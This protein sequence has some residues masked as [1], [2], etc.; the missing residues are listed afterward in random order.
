M[1]HGTILQW[2]R[3]I[4]DSIAKDEMLLELET[5]KAIVELPSPTDG[6]LLSILHESGEVNVDQVIGWIGQRGEAVPETGPLHTP[7]QTS[8]PEA[9]VSVSSQNA[10]RGPSAPLLAATPAARRRAKELGIDLSSVKGTGPGGRITEENVEGHAQAKSDL[11]SSR[12]RVLAEHVTEAWRNVP[13]IHIVRSMGMDSL[14]RAKDVLSG[15]DQPISYTDLVLFTLAKTLTRF[16][17]VLFSPPPG[18]TNLS[19]AFAVDTEHGVV[20]PAIPGVDKLTL[21]QLAEARRKLTSLAQARKLQPEHLQTANFT[22]TNLGMFG[23]DLFAPIINTP[24]I[25]ILAVGQIA[26]Q[27]VIKD[28]Q[29]CAGWRMWATL[30]ADHRHIDGALAAKFLA[31]WQD[32]LNRLPESAMT[33]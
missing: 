12:R 23:I 19:L 21:A 17:Q 18:A 5:D 20:T 15:K 1:E 25:A 30:A 10:E 14:V 33:S 8:S 11:P 4:G 3:K 16:P 9:S 13:H 6:I 2:V 27:A 32:E 28:G 22:L 7:A 29:V 24:Q 26:Q 31:V